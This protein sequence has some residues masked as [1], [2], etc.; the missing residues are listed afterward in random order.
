M[1]PRLRNRRLLVHPKGEPERQTI[2]DTP[3]PQRVKPLKRWL[4][5][6]PKA[7]R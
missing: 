1:S 7:M 5:R 4:P 6:L 3:K 2:W